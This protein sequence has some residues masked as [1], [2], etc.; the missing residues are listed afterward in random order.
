MKLTITVHIQ[1]ETRELDGKPYILGLKYSIT[2]HDIDVE[3]RPI[4]IEKEETDFIKKVSDIIFKI[5]SIYK[6]SKIGGY[7][8]HQDIY[9]ELDKICDLQEV[10]IDFE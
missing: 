6:A 1:R 9:A 3:Y 2:D 8:F 5:T 4:G 10:Q 7:Q